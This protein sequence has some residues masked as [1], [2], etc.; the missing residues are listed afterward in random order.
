[1]THLLLDN[2]KMIMHIKVFCESTTIKD[3]DDILEK[4]KQLSF[5]QTS[6]LKNKDFFSRK[7]L[8][9]W[10]KKSCTWKDNLMVSRRVKDTGGRSSTSKNIDKKSELRYL[11]VNTA[12][13]QAPQK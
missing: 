7:L 10:K 8:S 1:M 2:W 4:V 11:N 13:V 9:L 3:Y 6:Y 12:K 5:P